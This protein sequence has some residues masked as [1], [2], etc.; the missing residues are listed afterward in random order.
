MSEFDATTWT[1]PA[2][3]DHPYKGI[4]RRVLANTDEVMLVHYSVSEG[5]VFPEH[6]HDETVQAVYV[7]NGCVEL[8]GDH[9]RTLATGDSFIVHSGVRHGIEGVAPRSQLLDAFA[10]PIERYRS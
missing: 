6:E 9:E 3:I 8:T 5:S 4:E 10:P 7:V 2:G 1:A